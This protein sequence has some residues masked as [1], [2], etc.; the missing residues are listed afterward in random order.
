M[1]VAAILATIAVP[2]FS[3]LTASQR[4]KTASSELFESLLKARSES[5]KRNLNVTLSPKAGG[6]VGGWQTPDPA[7]AANI[8][9]TRGAAA[10]VT[11]TGPPSV[12]YRPSGRV[13]AGTAPSFLVTATAG[14]ST[15]YQCMTVDLTGRPYVVAA[16]TC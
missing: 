9:D 8:L 15:F 12:T 6:W 13:L 2:S 1:A 11:I 10:G 14:T 16:S 4:A 7:N 3:G 5:I